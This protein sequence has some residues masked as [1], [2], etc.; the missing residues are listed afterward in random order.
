MQMVNNWAVKATRCSD[1]ASTCSMG[2]AKNVKHLNWAR[3][4]TGAKMDALEAGQEIPAWAEAV[5]QCV[6]PLS[7]QMHCT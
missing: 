1:T 3:I 5:S 7:M 6:S 4:V 2:V